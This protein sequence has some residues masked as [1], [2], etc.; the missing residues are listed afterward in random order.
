[1]APGSEKSGAEDLNKDAFTFHEQGSEKSIPKYP[2]QNLGVI[3]KK[4]KNSA[5]HHP[6]QVIGESA[7]RHHS[8]KDL[9]ENMEISA[10]NGH[11]FFDSQLDVE[12]INT[13]YNR[14]DQHG[15]PL[16]I[17]GINNN[18]INNKSTPSF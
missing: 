17:S 13:N 15:K 16:T 5:H 8:M 14:Y 2:D 10:G 18:L 6:S 3:R 4:V 12:D 9:G 11:D 7:V 1:M